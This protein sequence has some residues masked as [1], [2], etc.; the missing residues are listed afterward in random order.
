VATDAAG[1]GINLQAACRFV[2]NLELPWNPMRLEQRIGRVDRIGQPRRVHAVNLVARGTSEELILGRLVGRIARV[3]DAIGDTEDPIGSAGA[4][5]AAVIA[6][7]MSL[8]D[9]AEAP[10]TATPPSAGPV[11]AS[12][13]AAPPPPDLTPL[14]IAETERLR[15]AREVLRPALHAAR[16]LV[17]DL[18]ARLETTAP[19]AHEMT[20]SSTLAPGVL[21]VFRARLIDGRGSLQEELLVPVHV[22]ARLDRAGSRAA[23]GLRSALF[24]APAAL[25]ALLRER[26]RAE[27]LARVSA[28]APVTA[29]AGRWPRDREAAIAGFV[30]R[31]MRPE[32]LGPV[33]AGLFDQRELRRAA[34]RRLAWARVER[35]LAERRAGLRRTAVLSVAGE[36]EAML[37]LWIG[38]AHRP[39]R[40]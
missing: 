3:L 20:G 11:A 36:P 18:R 34:A 16:R 26:A 40:R 7:G 28:L 30:G 17:T 10:C 22:E 33:Q 6:P 29:D 5:A 37:A 24:G 13:G 23:Y 39:E 9:P 15:H 35:E 21:C 2:V 32:R 1:Q 14:A 25:L 19:W 38:P 4:I 12:C 31:R 8:A 27:A